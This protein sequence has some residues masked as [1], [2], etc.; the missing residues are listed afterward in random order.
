MTEVT[1]E[2][3]AVFIEEAAR[4]IPYTYE[5]PVIDSGLRPTQAHRGDAGYDLRA[6]FN[7]TILPGETAKVGT[8]I[9]IA[10]PDGLAALVLSRSGLAAEG[11]VVANSPGL[12]DSG[13]RG[14][15]GVLLHN[16]NDLN[17]FV[18]RKGDRIA[19]LL[20]ISLPLV[21]FGLLAQPA[22]EALVTDRG[23]GGFGST[24]IA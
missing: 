11:L 22:F 16:N 4:V 12:I 5:I 23:E 24:G 15:I 19:Q 18:I 20:I 21:Q 17:D 8:G 7:A 1:A 14:E 6:S 3:E 9:R 2:W 10:L 13:Y